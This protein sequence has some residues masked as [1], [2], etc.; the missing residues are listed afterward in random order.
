MD[1]S[2]NFF[3]KS[4]SGKSTVETTGSLANSNQAETVGSLACLINDEGSMDSFGGKDA[5]GS[6]NLSNIDSSFFASNPQSET[7]GSLACGSFTSVGFSGGSDFGGSSV[8]SSSGG[9]CG[10]S[11]CGSFTSVC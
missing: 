6:E 8:G 5:F 1:F 7:A 3:A 2:F 10:G 11:S 9:D 4:T